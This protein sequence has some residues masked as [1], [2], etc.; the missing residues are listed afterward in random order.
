MLPNSYVS[1]AS[2]NPLS[3]EQAAPYAVGI[4]RLCERGRRR[5]LRFSGLCARQTVGQIAMSVILV[6]V[7]L[8]LAYVVWLVA[9]SVLKRKDTPTEDQGA[10]PS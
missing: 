8:Q 6:L 10:R 3:A 2:K 7:V 4:I 5:F 1:A 9:L